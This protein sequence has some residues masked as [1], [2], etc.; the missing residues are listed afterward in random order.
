VRFL[1]PIS[2]FDFLPKGHL[3]GNSDRFV[4]SSTSVNQQKSHYFETL[5]IIGEIIK[6]P[7]RTDLTELSNLCKC[8]DVLFTTFHEEPPYNLAC[9]YLN[10]TKG[11]LM[12]NGGFLNKWTF[13]NSSMNIV[14]SHQ[15]AYQLNKRLG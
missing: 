12:L 14:T 8:D 1:V 10:H 9:C 3:L 4:D 13:R 15:Q 2:E 5:D 6:I 11:A 7:K